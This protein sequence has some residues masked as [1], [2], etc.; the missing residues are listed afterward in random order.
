MAVLR[1]A[2]AS[3]GFLAVVAVWFGGWIALPA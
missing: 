1:E 3:A 2:L